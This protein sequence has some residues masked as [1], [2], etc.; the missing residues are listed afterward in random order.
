M[1][2]QVVH[3]HLIHGF[4]YW[5]TMLAVVPVL[6]AFVLFRPG[7]KRTPVWWAMTGLWVLFLPNAP[8]VLTDVIHVRGD[9]AETTSRVHAAAIVIQYAALM[10]LGL[11][12]Y[13]AAVALVRRYLLLEGHAGWRWPVEIT[14]HALCSVGIFLG[15]FMR[16]NSW[17]IVVRPTEVLQYVRVPHSST[18][19]IIAFTFVVLITATLALR[20]PLAIHDLR[21]ATR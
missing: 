1:G 15:R 16:L 7:T 21:R 12:L 14:L 10:G 20:V 8:Y 2:E 13:G 19:V 18:V 9:V 5:N 17:D 11:V 3:G 6:L 4:M